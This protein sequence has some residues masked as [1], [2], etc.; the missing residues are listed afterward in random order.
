MSMILKINLQEL[1]E[2]P[3]SEMRKLLNYLHFP[4]D[5]ER[6]ECIDKHSSGS[7]HRVHH[8]SEDPWS[9]EL[10]QMFDDTIDVANKMLI[11]KIGRSLPLTKYQYYRSKM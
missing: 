8:Q 1:T 2:D 7:F 4:V 3:I 5:E 11:E 9:H 10:H 6:L